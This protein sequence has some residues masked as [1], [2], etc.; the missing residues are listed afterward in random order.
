MRNPNRIPIILKF[1]R[2]NPAQLSMFLYNSKLIKSPELTKTFEDLWLANPDLRLG[3]AL[4]NYNIIEDGLAWNKEE[5]LWLIEHDYFKFEE[6]NFWGS[7]YDKNNKPLAKTQYKLLKDLD[8][9]HIKAILEFYKGRIDK[10]NSKYLNYFN[11]RIRESSMK[12]YRIS[13]IGENK[14][15]P[16]S[17]ISMFGNTKEFF[18]GYSETSP[19]I[20]ERFDLRDSFG[21]IVIS[22]SIVLD[23]EENSFKTLYS[24]YSIEE[25]EN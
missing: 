6:L 1:F 9:D 14:D 4:I 17:S 21:M 16:L 24:I 2:E 25:L 20:G 3:Q 18:E 5:D 19:L 12:K 8:I 23:V 10:I 7:N 22:T 11:K 13:K 15:N